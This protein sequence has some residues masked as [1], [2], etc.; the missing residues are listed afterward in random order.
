MAKPAETGGSA[1]EV[2][3]FDLTLEF[4]LPEVHAEAFA[5]AETAAAT[6]TSDT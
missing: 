4:K 3:E 5:V 6:E 2:C 1:D